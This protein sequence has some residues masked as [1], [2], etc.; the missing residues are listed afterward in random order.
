MTNSAKTKRYVTCTPRAHR[1]EETPKQLE[2]IDQHANNQ[3]N[4]D[5]EHDEELKNIAC[6]NLDARGNLMSAARSLF[7]EDHWKKMNCSPCRPGCGM[8]NG[9]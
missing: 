9:R 7:S 5:N 4:T 6:G 2:Q 1:E 3:T 8:G